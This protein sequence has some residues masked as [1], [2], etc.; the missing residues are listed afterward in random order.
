MKFYEYCE[1]A[2]I[3]PDFDTILACAFLE[4]RGRIFSINFDLEDAVQKAEELYM[5]DYLRAK[6]A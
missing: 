3:D 5:E 2:A 6:Q 4:A 1:M